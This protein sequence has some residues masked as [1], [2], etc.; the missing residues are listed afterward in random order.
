M[1]ER[2]PGRPTSRPRHRLPAARWRIDK[3]PGGQSAVGLGIQP[4]SVSPNAWTREPTHDV[5]S[6]PRKPESRKIVAIE[7]I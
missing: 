7:E 5:E 2:R 1:T 3:T 6:G 4:Y